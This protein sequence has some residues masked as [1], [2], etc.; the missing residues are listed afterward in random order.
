MLNTFDLTTKAAPSFDVGEIKYCGVREEQR[1]VKQAEGS[2]LH[3]H[4]IEFRKSMAHVNTEKAHLDESVKWHNPEYTYGDHK[5][6]VAEYNNNVILKEQLD[7]LRIR[8]KYSYYDMQGNLLIN[9]ERTLAEK[10]RVATKSAIKKDL[11][12]RKENMKRA[13][14]FRIANSF[15]KALGLKPKRFYKKKFKMPFVKN[16]M[17]QM[18]YQNK[19]DDALKKYKIKYNEKVKKKLAKELAAKESK[20]KSKKDM[21]LKF[22][23][24][25]SFDDQNSSMFEQVLYFSHSM[26]KEKIP[27]D[28]W[29]RLMAGWKKHYEE[30]YDVVIM[31]WTIHFSEKTPHIHMAGSNLKK[32]E[33]GKYIYSKNR[34]LKGKGSEMQDAFARFVKMSLRTEHEYIRGKKKT[35]KGNDHAPQHDAAQEVAATTGMIDTL[36]KRLDGDLSMKEVLG[37]VASLKEVYKG[38]KQAKKVLNAFQRIVKKLDDKSQKELLQIENLKER[39]K[40]E[41]SVSELLKNIL[42]NDEQAE[43]AFLEMKGANTIYKKWGLKRSFA[44]QSAAERKASK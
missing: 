40:D 24:E 29:V 16:V 32:D 15:R 13:I 34:I 31:D 8:R 20:Y 3:N 2:Y 25:E 23:V 30:K 18:R 38:N 10:L 41:A 4:D 22:D 26:A 11:A 14:K 33:N 44:N 27:Q 35:E 36:E 9:E 7:V 43:N 39:L 21:Q 37:Q 5:K 6:S 12:V 28:Q 1:T 42:M 17:Q 19:R